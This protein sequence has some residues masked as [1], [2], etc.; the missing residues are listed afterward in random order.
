MSKYEIIETKETECKQA[1]IFA[2]V[3]SQKQ[4]NGVSKEAQIS[5]MTNYCNKN[6]LKIVKSY[7][8][9]E[10]STIGDRPKFK[11]MIEF[12]K[13]QKQKTALVVHSVDR[14]QR[15]FDETSIIN[16]LAR[17][18]IIEVHFLKEN[19]NIDQDAEQAEEMQY[20]L[21]VFSAKMYISA[22]RNHVLKSQKF[23]LNNGKWQ[24]FAPIGYI[25]YR[26]SDNKAQIKLDEERAPLIKKL[27]LEYATGLHSLE[28]LCQF[29]REIGLSTRPTKKLKS[30]SISRHKINDILRNPFYCGTMVVKGKAYPHIYER[31]VSPELFNEVKE[32]LDN[33]GKKK[34]IPH[35]QIYG[36]KAFVFR[37]LV[38]CGICGCTITSEQHTKK[39]GLVF[40]Y[41]RCSHMR[42]NCNQKPV[43][44]SKLLNQLDDELFSKLQLSDSILLA[45]KKNVQMRLEEDSHI[46]A[47]LKR[48]NTLKLEE[49]EN[50]KSR[51]FDIYLEGGI[52]KE[53][54]QEEKAKMEAEKQQLELNA[55][56]FITITTEIKDVVERIIEITGNLSNIMKTAD[57]KIRNQLLK[58]LLKDCT[59]KDGKL[60]YN[61][62][63]PFSA[64]IS[65]DVKKTIPDYITN[66]LQEFNKIA[67]PVGLLSN[68]LPSEKAA[69]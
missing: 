66:N 23:N 10:S 5:A 45:V 21:N 18:G 63:E 36:K 62:R 32:I 27:F 14:L 43:P 8:I 4:E 9:T 67:Y 57:Y 51:L 33:R 11:E 35:Q 48:K 61:V 22:L 65:T 3:S 2:R 53:E 40:R 39:S 68:Y 31:I 30:H 44:E 6:G 50:K 17:D 1:V 58:L 37:G 29:A 41:L 59:L 55:Q 25:N 38:K 12:L 46:S 52:T 34:I 49:L 7:S 19:F 15:G 42:K 26:D 69:I 47:A 54:Y 24:G 16:K 13:K 28:S 20:D 56:K 64:F 60:T